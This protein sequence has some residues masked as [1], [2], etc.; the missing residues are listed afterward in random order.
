MFKKEKEPEG[1]E[2][3][4]DAKAEEEEVEEKEEED[5]FTA[6]KD[7]VEDL[8]KILKKKEPGDP[9][10][11]R[12]RREGQRTSQDFIIVLTIPE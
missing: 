2:T 4:E 1:C 7:K 11:L 3:E 9:L 12:L 6:I 5:P 8:E 10:M